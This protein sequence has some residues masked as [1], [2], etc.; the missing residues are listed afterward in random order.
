MFKGGKRSPRY[1]Q[2]R[3]TLDAHTREKTHVI[4]CRL[5]M[6]QKKEAGVPTQ[7]FTKCYQRHKREPRIASFLGMCGGG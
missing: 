6:S 5:A 3:I 1:Q 2:T 4:I 7:P